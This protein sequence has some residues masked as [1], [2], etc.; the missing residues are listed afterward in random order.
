MSTLG[1][2]DA[3]PIWDI[4][5]HIYN[6][7][8]GSATEVAKEAANVV[9]EELK[10]VSEGQSAAFLSQS[11][12]SFALNGST[13]LVPY[14]FGDTYSLKAAETSSSYLGSYAGY[15]LSAVAGLGSVFGLYKTFGAKKKAAEVITS[16]ETLTILEQ[17]SG[18]LDSL[19]VLLKNPAVAAIIKLLTP[20]QA[21][22]LK[23]LEETVPGF[24]AGIAKMPAAQQLLS[25]QDALKPVVSASA[26]LPA[27]LTQ[28][29]LSAVLRQVSAASSSNAMSESAPKKTSLVDSIM[30]SPEAKQI[31]AIINGHDTAKQVLGMMNEMS[32]KV[33]AKNAVKFAP[34]MAKYD[35]KQN[36]DVLVGVAK[37][38]KQTIELE[39]PKSALKL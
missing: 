2:K 1:P 36:T 28:V 16:P 11:V 33:L 23:Q 17:I 12:P 18:F 6:A 4:A 35:D 31:V 21:Q 34:T 8:A 32:L 22:A 29:D 9:T 20:Q 10:E 39:A 19:N 15:G 13:A 27:D 3:A 5:A 7:V 37:A 38:A 30:T 25:F 26:N 14:F 24:F